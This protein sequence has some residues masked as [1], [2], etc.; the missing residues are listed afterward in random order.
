MYALVGPQSW[1][2]VTKG[3]D[4]SEAA[5]IGGAHHQPVAAGR[6]DHVLEQL[7]VGAGRR[8]PDRLAVGIEQQEIKPVG[9][10]EFAVARH[11]RAGQRDLEI[12]RPAGVA[13]GTKRRD[14]A[15]ARDGDHEF[16]LVGGGERGDVE[17]GTSEPGALGPTTSGRGP[18]FVE[19]EGEINNVFNTGCEAVELPF[20]GRG[21]GFVRGGKATRFDPAPEDAG[22]A[23]RGKT[24]ADPSP[25]FGLAVEGANQDGQHG[26]P[27]DIELKL[28]QIGDGGQ[29]PVLGA[30]RPDGLGEGADGGSCTP[31]QVMT[32]TR[33]SGSSRS[34]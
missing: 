1:P 30:A 19:S 17:L 32:W 6:E 20:A 33:R 31:L 15:I 7:V 23:E 2:V 10:H 21:V 16:G 27:D 11:G 29:Q 28:S 12:A 9:G 14:G 3:K 22:H 8:A 34:S 18:D 26:D 4:V 24:L 5:G 25:R 13:G